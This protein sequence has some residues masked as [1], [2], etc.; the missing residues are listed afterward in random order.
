[1]SALS[2]LRPDV[3]TLDIEMP[4]MDGLSFLAKLMRHF[5]LPVVVC[6]S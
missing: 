2:Q 4:R 6:S 3:V 5:P 1:V